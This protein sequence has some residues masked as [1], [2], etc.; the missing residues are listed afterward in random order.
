MQRVLKPILTLVV[1]VYRNEGSIGDLVATVSQLSRLAGGR[2]EAVFVVDG[3]PDQSYSLLRSALPGAGFASQLITLSRNFGS[4][5]AIRLGLSRAQGH[6]IAVMAADL[7][8]P[9]ELISRFLDVLQGGERDVAFGVREA[10]HDALSSKLASRLFW[11]LYRRLV[12]RDIPSGGVDIFA[13]TAEFRD[14]LLNLGESNT[15]LLAQLF[16]LGG[17][18][19]FVPYVRRKRQ[20]GRS[21]W[22]VG[23]KLRYLSDSVFSFTDLPVRMLLGLGVLTLLVAVVMAA[24]VLLAKAF[25]VVAV[26]GY[27]GTMLTI[28]FFGAFNALGLGVVGE[29]AWR[30]YENTKA[31]PLVL[32]Q[33]EESFG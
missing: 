21:A 5:A 6:Y 17:R 29:Y 1:P 25:G 14:R 30:T 32:V 3:S 12:L 2:F 24:V 20:H 16:W 10:R 31:R 27:A 19:D 9:P 7:Q 8:E 26:P 18:R 22:T 4:F 13:M 33:S 23:K 11:A 15:S 28:L